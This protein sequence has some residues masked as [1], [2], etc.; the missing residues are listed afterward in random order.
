MS[1]AR[2]G[3]KVGLSERVIPLRLSA[4]QHFFKDSRV[5]TGV[6]ISGLQFGKQR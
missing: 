2:L 3:F 4:L 6:L 1:L 5:L